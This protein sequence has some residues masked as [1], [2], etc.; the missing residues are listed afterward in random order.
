MISKTR[1]VT[2]AAVMAL[3]PQTQCRLCGFDGCRPY[4]EAILSGTAKINRCPPGGDVT[5][6]ALAGLLGEEA[7]VW[8]GERGPGPRVLVAIDPK[9]CIGCARCLPACPVDAIVGAP[10]LLHAVVSAE[11]TGC[12][13]CLA[14]CPVDCF[15]TLA[16]ETPP[17]G[18]WPDRS[19]EEARRARLRAYRKTRRARHPQRRTSAHADRERKRREIREALEQARRERGWQGA[20]HDR[21]ITRGE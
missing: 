20:M 9:A 15:T 16:H 12:L 14:P 4:A 6:L 8:E 11:C 7:P 21:R 17:H 2:L 13:L 10:G 18:P 3:L 1:P 5:R 19:Q